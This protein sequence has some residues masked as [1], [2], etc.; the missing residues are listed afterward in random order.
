MRSLPLSIPNSGIRCVSCNLCKLILQSHHWFQTAHAVR[1]SKPRT[2]KHL[3][4]LGSWSSPSYMNVDKIAFKCFTPC[5][6]SQDFDD[7]SIAIPPV[8][9]PPSLHA[10]L[11]LLWAVNNL[12]IIF[13]VITP[14]FTCSLSKSLRHCPTIFPL[15]ELYSKTSWQNTWITQ[16]SQNLYSQFCSDIRKSVWGKHGYKN[17]KCLQSPSGVINLLKETSFASHVIYFQVTADSL[18]C[19]AMS[20]WKQY[21]SIQ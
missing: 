11:F 10:L 19:R 9:S 2:P 4:S 1:L 6:S 7:D 20:K 21:V 18:R 12:C 5:F 13:L 15:K 16:S 3:C 8:L 17:I 14:I